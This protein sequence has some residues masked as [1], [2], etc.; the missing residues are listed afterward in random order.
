MPV[1]HFVY[2]EIRDLLLA[3]SIDHALP[4]TSSSIRARWEAC[5]IFDDKKV[6]YDEDMNV[7]NRINMLMI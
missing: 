5:G 2:L 6:S 7:G 4:S 3:R 1:P